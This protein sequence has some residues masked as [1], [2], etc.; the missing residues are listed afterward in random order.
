LGPFTE[1]QLIL[2]TGASG[3]IGSHLAHT[4]LAS[5][6]PVRLRLLARPFSDLRAFEGYANIQIVRVERWDDAEQL[7]QAF[8]EVDYVFHT[9][10]ACS[11]WAKWGDF[12]EANVT[13]AKRLVEAAIAERRR[14]DSGMKRLL[15]ISTA[16]VYGFPGNGPSEDVSPRDIGIPYVTTK[17]AG[18]TAVLSAKGQLPVTVVRPTS[19]YGPR[20]KDF[21]LEIATLLK[22]RMMLLVSGEVDAGLIYVDD[23][24]DGLIRAATSPNAVGQVYNMWGEEHITWRRYLDRL[25]E[26]LGYPRPFLS[27]PFGPLL[28]CGYLLESL[29]HLCGW[30]G[31]RPL[32]TRHAVYVMGR[33]QHTPIDKAKRELGFHPRISLDAGLEQS[34][35]WL[36][37]LPQFRS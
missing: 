4:L 24:V 18:E 34:V 17:I 23:L 36:K 1:N 32:L 37:T 7:R 30:Y 3:F 35:E 9:A 21:V 27:L 15:H 13:M 19:V 29:Y 28:A 10:A 11:D 14:Q 31:A 5:S 16:D 26:E 33:H 12:E 25:A 20:S 2:I 22:S 6:P 8:R